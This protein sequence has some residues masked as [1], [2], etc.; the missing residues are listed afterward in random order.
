MA[1]RGRIRYVGRP[2]AGGAARSTTMTTPTHVRDAL[3]GLGALRTDAR[4]DQARPLPGRCYTDAAWLA[5]ERTAVFGRTW[6]LAAHAGQFPEHGSYASVEVAGEP[7]VIVRDGESLRAYYNVCRHRGGPLT[8]G[9]GRQRQFT[10]RY[11]GWSYALDGRVLRAPFMAEELARELARNAG[12]LDLRPVQV[13]QWAGLVFVN[14]DPAAGPLAEF[15]GSLTADAAHLRLERL[16]FHLRRSYPVAANWKVYV[17]NYLEGYHVPAVHPGLNR[18]IDFRRYVTELGEHH[19]VQHAP[20]AAGGGAGRVYAADADAPDA[21]YYWLFPNMMLNCYQ[22]LLQVN[23]VEPA[24]V[25]RCLVHFDWYLPAPPV[26]GEA[27][28]RF[29]RL[30][31]FSD[32]VQAEDAAICAAVQR[33]VASTAFEPGPYSTQ[34]ETGVHHF[35]TLYAR[36][37]QRP[38]SR[39]AR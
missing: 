35:H 11:H 9:C 17:D 22:G 34:Y 5:H 33:N 4:I 32:E 24:G 31:A 38:A 28:T 7:V 23:V 26:D 39:N 29:E 36:A 14:L 30:A 27:L 18:E 13:A 6:N 37:L 1:R 12:T 21:R 2:C 8:E 19:S 10:C 20:I 15:L 25:D 3:D 16:R